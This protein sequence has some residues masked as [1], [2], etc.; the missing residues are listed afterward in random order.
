MRFPFPLRY[1]LPLGLLTVS[2]ATAVLAMNKGPWAA[3]GMATAV[4]VL[5]WGFMHLSFTKRIVRLL[6][7]TRAFSEAAGPVPTPLEG[8]DE[9]AE[10]SAAFCDAAAALRH[11]E[12]YLNE[13]SQSLTE[14]NKELESIV[15]VTS[16]DLRSPLVNV[17]G[18]SCELGL[19]AQDI[20]RMLGEPATPERDETMRDIADHR[21]PEALRFIDAGVSKMDALLKGLLR[22]SRLGRASL[23][24]QL[25][26]MR[27]L[28]QELVDAM[29]FQL[30][31]VGAK[32][33]IVGKLPDCYGDA[34][35]LSQVFSNLLDNAFKYREPSRPLTVKFD[36]HRSGGEAIYRVIDN[37]VGIAEE[38]QPRVFEMF[39]RLDPGK[40]P[41]EGLGLTIADRVLERHRG[42]ITVESTPGV[43]SAFCV[44]LPAVEPVPSSRLLP[45]PRRSGISMPPV[46]LK[47]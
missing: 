31:R 40:V 41:G 21:I 47:V 3:I 23:N 12:E 36:G 10:I 6:Q 34:G 19:L 37:G 32:V 44:H 27:D 22:L 8:G 9:I 1:T 24:I 28:I 14:K 5:F 35:Q 17:Q 16:H 25:V 26:N 38:H 7:Q 30:S 4:G 46:K 20:K 2:I 43:G 39:H 15:Y 45:G 29:E 33:E 18:F 13:V 11:R 42:R